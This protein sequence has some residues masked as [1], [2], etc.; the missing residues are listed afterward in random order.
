MQAGTKAEHA[1]CALTQ[2]QVSYKGLSVCGMDVVFVCVFAS[3][4]HSSVVCP[5][6]E[7]SA[8]TLLF[9]HFKQFILFKAVKC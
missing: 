4:V 2:S 1:S 8:A 3:F 7:P 5:R 6:V 9:L